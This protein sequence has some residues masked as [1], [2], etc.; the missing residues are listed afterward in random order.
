MAEEKWKIMSKDIKAY[1]NKAFMIRNI[2]I[3]I[4]FVVC[5]ILTIFI[6][7][8]NKEIF[9]EVLYENI[10]INETAG[11]TEKQTK[12]VLERT[13][14]CT[15]NNLKAFELKIKKHEQNSCD[16]MQVELYN[17]SKNCKVQSWKIKK[18]FVPSENGLEFTLDKLVTQVQGDEFKLVIKGNHNLIDKAFCV[19]YLGEE[20]LQKSSIVDIINI[21]IMVI[22][23]ISTLI[24]IGF[25]S[26][27]GIKKM[28]KAIK[29]IEK[30]PWIGV[31]MASIIAGSALIELGISYSL[32]GKE[33]SLGTYFNWYRYIYLVCTLLIAECIY[34]Y[35]KRIIGKA[36]N[37]FA[38]V[39]V[40]AGV[41]LITTQPL[42][43]AINWDGKIH[44]ERVVQMGYFTEY[45]I[46]QADIDMI[47][48]NYS[49]TK[50]M[51][52]AW[53]NL[54][55]SN[56]RVE[57][58]A[59]TIPK[60]YSSIYA[61]LAYIPAAVIYRICTICKAPFWLTFSAGKIMNYLLYTCL[62]YYAMKR[63]KWGKIICMAVGML[64]TA[65]MLATNYGYD[66]W[67]T[68]FSILG[69]GYIIGE[70][71]NRESK[72]TCRSCAV[73]LGSF[74]IG[75]S[76][77]AIYFPLTLLGLI[78][79]TEKFA[80]KKYCYIFRVVSLFCSL[81]IAGSFL[82]PTIMSVTSG[83]GGGGDARGG[84]GVNSTKQIMFIMQHPLEY[85]KIL[86][87]FL[88]MEYFHP[89][90]VGNYTTK[91]AYLG[92]GKL[93]IVSV[94]SILVSAFAGREY[95]EKTVLDNKNRIW[96][97][98]MVGITV[99]LFSTA[100]YVS[101]TPVG[102]ETINGCQ[103]RYMIPCL[104]PMLYFF[105]IA[106]KENSERTVVSLRHVEMLVAILSVFV[107]LFT[108]YEVWILGLF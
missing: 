94:L 36:E 52:D 37:L 31:C 67:V 65:M 108:Y 47:Y 29:K 38:A 34:L 13:F 49:N 84:S 1:Q 64:P 96:V 45:Q 107:L 78:I 58:I 105:G 27:K 48:Q 6:I 43:A 55:Q 21:F 106:R 33:N 22:A 50:N 76:P 92:T 20:N 32:V 70:L 103:Q 40:L 23:A 57:E 61:Y 77:K 104:F 26:I 81:L 102:Y 24:F 100:L 17:I 54:Q 46:T 12:Q 14:R 25:V 72:I 51:G 85:T 68:G 30:M 62:I 19:V 63:L 44:Y 87:K 4:F 11:A 90:N 41:L 80:K 97:L 89:K 35:G 5:F 86:M 10:C 95:Q 15:G 2:Q 91:M 42:V 60:Q 66:H 53:R 82:L 69:I 88:V 74:L 3:G 16:N 28:H 9:R 79:P 71:Q 101:F 8:N 75:L 59:I 7:L 93:S 39:M 73:I 99:V 56:S 98:G 83:V 18:E